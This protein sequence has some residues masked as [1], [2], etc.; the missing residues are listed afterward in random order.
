MRASRSGPVPSIGSHIGVRT[1]AGWTELQ[2]M[3]KPCEA[4]HR[5]TVFEWLRIAA[6]EE[7]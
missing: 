7:A 6:L 2:R 3:A 1:A 5:A 4:R